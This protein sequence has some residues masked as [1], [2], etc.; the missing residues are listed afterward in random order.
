METNNSM[1]VNPF[2]R[3]EA[4]RVAPGPDSS[5]LS[6]TLLRGARIRLGPGP[7]RS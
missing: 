7:G 4:Q 2:E 3:Y 1:L 6:G 5:L